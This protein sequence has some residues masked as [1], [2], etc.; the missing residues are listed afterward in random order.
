M[1]WMVIILV[2]M[3]LL[4]SMMWVMPTRKQKYQASLRLKAKSLGFQV[5]LEK[6]TPPRAQGE[7][8]A[9]ERNITAYRVLRHDLTRDQK[10]NFRTWQVYRVN[11]IANIGLVDGWS[12]AEGERILTELELDQL[13]A[14]LTDLPKGVLSLESTPAYVGAHWDEG[15]NS[16]NGEEL[17]ETL[18]QQLKQLSEGNF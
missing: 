12:W 13:N 6:M 4:G 16:D 18:Y 8:E 9:E 7:M 3:S 11:S 14:L 1:E 5:I 17:M 10:N 2:M 15:G